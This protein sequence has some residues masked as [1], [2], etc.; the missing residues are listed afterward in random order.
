MPLTRKHCKT[1]NLGE[2]ADLRDFTPSLIPSACNLS[3]NQ[4][5]CHSS[6]ASDNN[7]GR[8][9]LVIGQRP[10]PSTRGTEQRMTERDL[11][12]YKALRATIRQRGTARM[13]VFVT[14][15]AAWGLVSMIANF[16]S[17]PLATLVPLVLLAGVFEA[18]F[19]L[20]VGVERIG[21]Y[22]QVFYEDRWEQ[23]AMAFGAPLSGSGS[24][25]LFVTLFGLAAICNFMPV[26]LVLPVRVE[27]AVIGGAHALFIIRLIVARQVASR[28]RAADLERFRQI[29]TDNRGDR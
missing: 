14:G 10:A 9:S 27:L 26:L 7:I 8:L 29:K 12:E 19:G 6:P 1:G 28:Q 22:L 17:L 23:T 3:T 18:V 25:P 2:Q 11:E 13:W 24:D 16:V 20:H 15:F 21:R 4:V 5:L